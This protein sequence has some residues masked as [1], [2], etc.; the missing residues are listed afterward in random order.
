MSHTHARTHVHTLAEDFEDLLLHDAG[1]GKSCLLTSNRTSKLQI[2]S[3]VTQYANYQQ[4]FEPMSEKQMNQFCF[5]CNMGTMSAFLLSLCVR[6][7]VWK[8]SARLGVHNSE[9][10]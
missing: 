8:G 2:G 6:R 10:L 1:V 4:Y 5:E 3:S 7:P 9:V